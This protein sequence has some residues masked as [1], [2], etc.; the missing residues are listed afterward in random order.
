MGNCNMGNG[1]EADSKGRATGIAADKEDQAR[2]A[3]GDRG[4]GEGKAKSKGQATGMAS[5][6]KD[7]V[8]HE[9][10][11]PDGACPEGRKRWRP[12]IA[13]AVL[14]ALLPDALIRFGSKRL[15]LHCARSLVLLRRQPLLGF[16]A[17]GGKGT[18]NRDH[19]TVQRKTSPWNALH[20]AIA[21]CSALAFLCSLA[22][23]GCC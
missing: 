1:T 5:D 13:V 4:D 22:D 10:E 20:H 7:Q 18:G 23:G 6:P 8:D 17:R 15:C 12:T 19:P 2:A 3:M 9:H 14:G 11:Q 16:S 21:A